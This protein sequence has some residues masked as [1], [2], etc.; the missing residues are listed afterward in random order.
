MIVRALA[1]VGLLLA[2]SAGGAPGGDRERLE[3]TW[4]L[5]SLEING[6]VVPLTDAKTGRPAFVARLAVKGDRY[7]LTAGENR[8]AMT[9]RLDPRASPKRIDL[10]ALAGPDKG[11][12]FQGIYK[13]E[14][15]AFTVCRPAD[16][17][18]ARPKTFAT[19]P[20]SGLMLGVWKRA[21]P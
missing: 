6:Q 20:A 10:T 3:G 5:S 16:P 7:V 4:V 9:H 11:Q 19:R 8:L 2:G 21:R 15:D 14:G 13:L 1:V 17:G 18:Q 12:T